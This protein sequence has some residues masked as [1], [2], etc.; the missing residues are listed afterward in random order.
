MAVSCLIVEAMECFAQSWPESTGRSRDA[1]KGFLS[2]WPEFEPFAPITDD[3]YKHIRCGILF[4]AETTGGWRIRRSGPLL[5][6]KTINATA[7][8][9]SLHVALRQYAAQLREGA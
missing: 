4:H 6:E 3:F 5:Q 8:A 1:F 7:F 2:R 9:N